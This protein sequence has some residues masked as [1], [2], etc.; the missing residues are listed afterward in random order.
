M[1][2]YDFN[3]ELDRKAGYYGH[4]YLALRRKMNDVQRP[5]PHTNLQTIYGDY[6]LF[7]QRPF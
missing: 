7:L 2:A 4:E 1:I 5:I 6:V 3:M